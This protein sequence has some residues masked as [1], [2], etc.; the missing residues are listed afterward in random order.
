MA[1]PRK[2]AER[3]Q[4]RSTRNLP[5]PTAE[6]LPIAPPDLA[7]IAGDGDS[8]PKP[9]RT[10]LVRTKRDWTEFWDSDLS[11]YVKPTDLPALRRL[12]GWRDELARIRDRVKVM[13][14]NADEQPYVTGSTGQ[15]KANPLY[16]LAADLDHKA[17]QI[18][19]KIVALED[20]FPLTP[21]SRLGL[22]V[23]EQKGMNLAALNAKIAAQ[24]R[25]A[26]GAPDPRAA[27]RDAAI[28]AAE[29]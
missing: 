27:R 19:S 26:D 7:L 17:I 18:E 5:E 3:R 9:D 21:K 4:N 11:A 2:P 1:R 13:N 25:E 10:W 14:R 6:V 22:G 15:V 8:T 20:R 12:F 24:L 29:R 23:T 28:D 16:A